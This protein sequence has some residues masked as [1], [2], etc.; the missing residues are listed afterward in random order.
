MGRHQYVVR[1]RMLVERAICSPLSLAALG[2]RYDISR[3]RVHQILKREGVCE[4]R[5]HGYSI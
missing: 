1:N 3:Q 2:R 4:A 5:Q